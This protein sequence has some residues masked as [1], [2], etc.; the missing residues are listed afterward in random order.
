M[1]RTFNN[2][3]TGAN[4]SFRSGPIVP[5][6]MFLTLSTTV[7]HASNGASGWNL[8]QVAVAAAFGSVTFAM[9]C[10]GLHRVARA[11]AA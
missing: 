5:L 1:L 4:G 11:S 7:A 8:L 2:C 9:A 10:Y 3:I 6:S